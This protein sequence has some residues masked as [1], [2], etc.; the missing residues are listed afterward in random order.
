MLEAAGG[1][2]SILYPLS[3]CP[4]VDRWPPTLLLNQGAR[5]HTLD[6]SWTTTALQQQHQTT[7]TTTTSRPSD[8]AGSSGPGE[9][10]NVLS[11][12]M[13]FLRINNKCFWQQHQSSNLGVWQQNTPDSSPTW[14][15]VGAWVGFLVREKWKFLS[16]G[17]NVDRRY[18]P[19]QYIKEIASTGTKWDY[20]YLFVQNCKV[21][22]NSYQINK[23]F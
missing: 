16:G 20:L 2:S 10:S 5:G 11:C 12:E 13:K 3:L 19:L 23:G 18:N 4:P 7:T 21:S 14:I 9:M 22:F 15:L 1:H 17:Q 6:D 8:P